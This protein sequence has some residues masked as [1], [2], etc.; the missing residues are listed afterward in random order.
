MDAMGR[1]KLR[2]QHLPPRMLFRHGAY[3]HTPRLEGRQVWVRL[4]A[5]FGE[6]LRLYYQREQR[7]LAGSTVH[8]AIARYEREVLPGKAAKTQYDYRAYLGRLRPIFGDSKLSSVRRSD[9]AQYLDRRSAKVAANREVACL[10]SVFRNA[11]RWGWCEEN[12]CLGAPRNTERRRTR[13]PSEAELAALRVAAKPQ[14]RCLLDLELLTGLRKS[15]LLRSGS[16]ISRIAGCASR[17]R[18]PAPRL[19]SSGRS[20]SARSSRLRAGF[21]A[22]W[23]RCTSSP[24]ARA[25]AT[26]QAA[27][28]ASGSARSRGPESKA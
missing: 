25:S 6:A 10:S 20:N 21:G 26:P 17:C 16:R 4:S 24:T 22:G 1:Q 9:I 11:I 18:K 12:P 23:D 19:P 5:D 13:L 8:D 7:T 3:W 2:N 15:D 28:T 27:G 14:M